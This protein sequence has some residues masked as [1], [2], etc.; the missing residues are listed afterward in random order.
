MKHWNFARPAPGDDDVMTA[1]SVNP[2]NVYGFGHKAYYDHVVDCLLH[3]GQ[4]PVDG[5]QGRKSLELIN[6]IYESVETRREVPLRFRPRH[7]RLG[8]RR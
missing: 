2:P 7:A 6:A 3:G 1:F 8:E 4:H 5:L